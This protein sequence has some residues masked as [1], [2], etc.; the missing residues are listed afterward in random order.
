MNKN[1]V[2]GCDGDAIDLNQVSAFKII[3]DEQRLFKV[4]GKICT[5]DFYEVFAYTSCASVEL[6][7][8]QTKEDA[9]NFIE[10]HIRILN[11]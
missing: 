1:F 4:E 2:V 11:S 9:V 6:A 10:R 5:A 3:Y 8:F 7:E